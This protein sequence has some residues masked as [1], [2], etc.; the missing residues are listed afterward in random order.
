MLGYTFL[1]IEITR[2]PLHL[3]LAGEVTTLPQTHS[4]WGGA[5]ALD[6]VYVVVIVFRNCSNYETL[7][8]LEN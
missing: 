1:K 5:S 8:Q 4:C 3:D 7:M 2:K 6:I